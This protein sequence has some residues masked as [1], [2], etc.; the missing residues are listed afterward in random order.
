MLGLAESGHWDKVEDMVANFAAEI[1]AWG[2]IPNG[3][4]TYYLQPF[5]ALLLL[6][7]E[8]PLATHDGDQV[9]ENLPAAAG[10]RVSLLDGRSGTRWLPAAPTNGRCGWRTARCSTATGT[11]ATPP[12]PESSA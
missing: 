1:D 12:R 3:N 7:G 5:A 2:H 6:Y 11:I 9:L 4:R 8:P 10:E